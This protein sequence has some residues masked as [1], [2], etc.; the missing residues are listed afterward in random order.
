MAAANA[1]RNRIARVQ[2][3]AL[4]L[5]VDVLRIIV[6]LQHYIDTQNPALLDDL[7]IERKR[8]DELRAEL[9]STTRIPEVVQLLNKYDQLLPRRRASADSIIASLQAS[10]SA[11]ALQ[12]LR[13]QRREDDGLARSYLRDIIR[14]EGQATAAAQQRTDL[15]IRNIQRNLL[16]LNLPLLLLIM[17]YGIILSRSI[18]RPLQ[19]LDA[20]TKRVGK[21]DFSPTVVHSG[22]DEINILERSFNDMSE[23]LARIDRSKSEFISLVSHQLRTPATVVKHS[24]GLILEGYVTDEDK[25]QR[26]I[27][28]AY[29]TNDAQLAIVDDILNVARVDSGKLVVNKEQTEIN[30]MVDE[31]ARQLQPCAQEKQ[32]KLA[33]TPDS[34]PAI[35][36]VDRLK[37]TMV[38]ENLVNN[39]LKY[40]PEKGVVELSVSQTPRSIHIAVSDNGIGISKQEQAKLFRKFGRIDNDHTKKIPGTGLGL[41]LAKRFVEMHKGRITVQSAPGKGSTFEVILPKS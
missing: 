5:D 18:T 30:S 6:D 21:G 1:E 12:D 16:L 15:A 11:A 7:A 40:T 32:Q 25:K 19:A 33:V 28:A 20:M 41:Y 39:A 34:T 22:D 27:K 24:L 26:Y 9:R 38:I 37:I 8:S 29:D 10:E 14:I 2:Q 17:I 3:A 36:E 23:S 13:S 4:E 31:I 35:A